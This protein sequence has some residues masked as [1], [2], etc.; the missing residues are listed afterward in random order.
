MAVVSSSRGDVAAVAEICQQ[1]ETLDLDRN[2]SLTRVC[3]DV[4]RLLDVD[5]VCLYSLDEAPAGL[6]L[7]RFHASGMPQRFSHLFGEFLGSAPRR[8][9]LYDA[10]RPEPD[11][12]NRVIE[13]TRLVGQGGLPVLERVFAPVGLGDHGHLRALLC[14][15]ASLLGW[16]GALSSAPY[17]PRHVRILRALSR[18]VHA[19]LLGQRRLQ[20]ARLA[21]AALDALIEEIASPAFIVDGRASVCESNAAGRALLARSDRDVHSALV[22]AFAGRAPAMPVRLTR[23]HERALAPHWLAIFQVDAAA[24]R[25]AAATRRFKLTPRES[26]VV[27]WIA[28]GATN[29]R[30]AAELGCSERTVELHVTHILDKAG[31]ASRTALVAALLA[32]T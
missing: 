3:D 15:G 25:V 19:R 30:I 21:A 17:T 2:D 8:W 11:Q 14:E 5:I 29:Q 13:S 23:L 1:L 12:R 16:F 4:R 7:T 31:V 22:D 9:G 32:V 27:A 10:A 26:E 24:A 18:P 20:R 28:R 6:R